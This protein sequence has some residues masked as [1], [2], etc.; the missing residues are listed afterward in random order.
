VSAYTDGPPVVDTLPA[1]AEPSELSWGPLRLVGFR[2]HPVA[3]GENEWLEFYWRVTDDVSD[4]PLTLIV[5][6][7]DETGMVWLEWTEQVLPF[8]PPAQWPADRLV[9]TE[10]R[11]PLASDMAPV[12]YNVEVEPAS[13]G[14]PRPVGQLTVSRPTTRAP[15]PRPQ[16]RFEGGIELLASELTSNRFRAGFPLLGSLTWRAATTPAT[17]YHLRVRLTDRAG[18]EVAG[19][20]MAPSAAGF[21]TSAWRPDDRVAGRLAFP[22]PADL[23]SGTYRVEI[24]LVSAADGRVAPVRHWYGKRDWL[25][26]GA[27][28]VEA[29][30]LVTKLPADVAHRLEGVRIGEVIR[31]RGYDLIREE[32]KLT[33]TLYWQ[34]EE[35]PTVNYHVFVHVGVP[36]APP[37]AQA[38]GVP[39]VWL[40]PTTTW[41]SD[42]VIADTHVVS[43]AGVPP[44]RYDLLVGLYDPANAGQRPTTAVNGE[45]NSDGYVLLQAVEVRE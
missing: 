28:Q 10:L 14:Q 34:A 40:R 4:E 25:N 13:L 17:D 9:Q 38:D 1:D 39:G 37:I 8:Y 18:H 16:A 43:L 15:A 7:R 33:L 2:T 3:A 45:V 20:E 11:L 31:L 36:D 41:R 21:P 27:V 19:G 29:W 30:P 35:S 23:D 12:T 44:G 24:G 22:L 6:L 42:E 5:K 26:I 32:E